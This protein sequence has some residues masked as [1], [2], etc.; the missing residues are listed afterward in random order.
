ME[1]GEEWGLRGGG[2]RGEEMR[3]AAAG[4]TEAVIIKE[5]N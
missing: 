3:G 5:S 1:K 4:E 2:V